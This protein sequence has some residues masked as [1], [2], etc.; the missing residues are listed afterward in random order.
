MG[1]IVMNRKVIHGFVWYTYPF[2]LGLDDEAPADPGHPFAASHGAV[3]A[4]VE[5]IY[6]RPSTP[7]DTG[8]FNVPHDHAYLVVTKTQHH[9][10]VHDGWESEPAVLGDTFK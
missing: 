6:H 8:L 10:I 2:F 4:P 5:V 1:T 9:P 3:H 7:A